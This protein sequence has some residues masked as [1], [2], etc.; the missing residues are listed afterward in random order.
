MSAARRPTAPCRGY[1]MVEVML[2]MGALSLGATGV[3]AVQ[4][5]TL[6][7]NDNARRLNTATAIAAQ[8]VERLRAESLAWN[9]PAGQPDDL[10]SDTQWLRYATTSGTTWFNPIEVQNGSSTPAGSPDADILGFDLFGTDTSP[11]AYCTKMRLTRLAAYPTV[12]RVELRVYWD[13]A[14]QPLTCTAL[15]DPETGDNAKYG[16]VSITTAVTQ[17]TAP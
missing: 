14:R 16:F 15:P 1:T 10:T 5:A 3:L 13:R 8:W 11:K 6:L 2:A 9:A 17:N 12:I 4:K 7:G